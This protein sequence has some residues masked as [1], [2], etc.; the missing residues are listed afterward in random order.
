MKGLI[1]IIGESF[2]LGG[3]NTRIRGVPESYNEQI[4]A[5]NSHINFLDNLKNKFNY[6]SS[7]Y[8]STYD[9]N[10][11]KNLLDVYKNYLIGHKIYNDTIGLIQLF[12]NSIIDNKNDLHKYDFVFYFRIDLFLK[13]HFIDIFNPSWNTIRFPTICWK[14]DSIYNGKPRVNDMMLFIPNKFFDHLDNMSICHEA[15][16]LFSNNLNINDNDMDVMIN[17]YHDSDSQKDLNPLYYI[18]NRPESTV[19]HSEN[20]IFIRPL[21]EKFTIVRKNNFFD[22]IIKIIIFLFIINLLFNIL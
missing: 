17:T 4:N 13:N 21:T 18:V 10:Y 6:N 7:V 22:I 12:K 8:I 5:C 3:Q 9:T 20:E 14:K 11:N 19:W 1:I 16:Y 15:W 2:R